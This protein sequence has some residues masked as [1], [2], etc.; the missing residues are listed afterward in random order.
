MIIYALE[1]TLRKDSKAEYTSEVSKIPEKDGVLKKDSDTMYQERTS[2]VSAQEPEQ[3]E[4]LPSIADGN[5]FAPSVENIKK[6][7]QHLFNNWRE[8][9]DST[10]TLTIHP[11]ELN[12]ELDKLLYSDPDGHRWVYGWPWTNILKDK[13][14]NIRKIIIEDGVTIAP[15]SSLERIFSGCAIDMIIGLNKLDTSLVTNMSRM[16]EGYSG[17]TLDV[18]DLR[19]GNVTN[20]FRMFAGLPSRDRI[21]SNLISLDL[22]N[23]DTSQ[24]NY[25]N[26][27]FYGCNN[28]L[29]L[30]VSRFDT[31]KVRT[32]ESMFFLVKK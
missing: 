8:I 17:T 11:H 4:E 23:F 32:M 7:S 30:D 29:M 5:E 16:F 31:S 12:L 14:K 2:E 21:N 15:Y 26:Y 10:H 6:S 1:I 18:E 20:M 3:S 22:G 24:V 19:T 25:M 9:D 27:M 13:N 28:V